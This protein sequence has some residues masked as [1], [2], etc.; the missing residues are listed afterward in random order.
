MYGIHYRLWDGHM[1]TW[2]APVKYS[3]IQVSNGYARLS[4]IVSICNMDD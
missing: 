2:E 3:S 4:L 1:N